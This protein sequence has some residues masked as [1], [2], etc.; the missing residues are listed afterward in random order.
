MSTKVYIDQGVDRKKITNLKRLHD[1]EVV[2]VGHYEQKLRHA[3][4]IPG[5][6]ML[7]VSTLGGGDYLAGDDIDDIE[8][9]M[10]PNKVS[11]RFDL[12]HLYSAYHAKCEYFVTNNP[13]DFIRD[14]RN[15]P[16]S[17]GK[18]EELEKILTGMKIVTTDELR[19]LLSGE[20]FPVPA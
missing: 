19:K 9:I 17:N 7:G 18:R 20:S 13:K 1:L 3:D 8:D 15:D 11:D 12:A 4:S 6:F 10:H 14:I 16:S 5:V 2:H